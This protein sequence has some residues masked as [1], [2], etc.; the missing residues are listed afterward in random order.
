[1]DNIILAG[2]N[3]DMQWLLQLFR[4]QERLF[5]FLLLSAV[6]AILYFGANAAPH[7]Q[8]AR[9]LGWDPVWYVP[10]VSAFIVPYISLFIM[11]LPYFAIPYNPEF[12][13]RW[14]AMVVICAMASVAVYIALPLDM[15]HPEHM[16]NDVFSR[17][18][19]LTYFVDVRSNFFPSQHVIL[20]FLMAL[21]IGH[22]RPRW[23]WPM[24]VWAALI[25]VSTL[26]VRQHYLVY[27]IS[28]LAMALAAWAVFVRLKPKQH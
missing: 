15:P 19:A 3:A 12:F 10:F 28:G 27:V 26:F 14:V 16:G 17:M 23:R 4:E 13:R 24:L 6:L 18:V 5:L 21:G 22:E 9:V 8:P 7:L 2:N 1:L 25:A 11:P 20:A